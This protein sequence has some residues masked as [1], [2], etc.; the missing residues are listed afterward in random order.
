MKLNGKCQ[1]NPEEFI[2]A[3]AR[4]REGTAN[5]PHADVTGTGRDFV[6]LP[7][8]IA[9]VATM[10]IGSRLFLGNISRSRG[11]MDVLTSFAM[12]LFVIVLIETLAPRIVR[13]I[14][15][16][17]AGT[18]LV[19]FHLLYGAYF[20]FFNYTVPFDIFRQWQD[21][22]VVGKYGG[23]LIS[24]YELVVAVVL[25]LVFLVWIVFRSVKGKLLLFIILLGI[26]AI[27]WTN[28]LTRDI[29]RSAN[30]KAALPD[31]LHKVG[32][33]HFMLKMEKRR[34]LR[35]LNNIET[36]I[37]RHLDGYRR[38]KDG[39]IAVD[40]IEPSPKSECAQYNI[41]LIL[42][43]SV[44]AYECGFLGAKPSFTPRLDELTRQ[45]KVYTD[46]YSNGTRTV[47]AE[48]SLLCS[49]YPNPVGSLTY[50]INPRINITSLPQ[51]LSEF[52]YDTLWFSGYTA[53]FHNKRAFLSHHGIQ[54]IFDRD[55]LPKPTQ[56]T[57]G[58]GMA[59]GEMFEHVWSILKDSNQPF[60]A[61]ITTLSNHCGERL[62]Y[63]TEVDTPPVEGPVPFRKYMQGTYYTDHTVSD[64]I[65]KVR[66]STLADNT[67]III[68]GDHGLWLFPHGLKDP[69]QRLETFFRM[70]LCVWGPRELIGPG[71]DDTLGSHID[72]AP[73]VMDMLNIRRTNTFLGQSLLNTDISSNDRYV[74]AFFG[75]SSYFRTGDVL[76]LPKV[77]M[78]TEE[79]QTGAYVR[80]EEGRLCGRS[81]ISLFAL[82]GDLLRDP[83]AGTSFVD[84]L[85][86]KAISKRIDDITLLT[87][88]GTYF[89]AFQG[90]R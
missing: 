68:T 46:Y 55:V 4:Q 53:D 64:F 20:R 35:I 79:M 13:G 29:K 88:Y 12:V 51:I 37:P 45:A 38:V 58:W 50:L 87:A 82:R 40:P 77:T 23:N 39:G 48:L 81:Q 8:R 67:I 59:D 14:L 15:L 57:I 28:R 80:G 54:K 10:L 44:R 17:L 9:F 61:Q 36:A 56:P 5:A 25:P 66:S 11:R 31:I 7:V 85:R 3:A 70:P 19:F 34:F 84:E 63:P 24:I 26:M 47:S 22:F 18:A 32:R 21:L 75:N 65:E 42:M 43:E 62:D 2:G 6:S 1:K 76:A 78:Q 30:T 90:I 69:L 16:F 71:R 60:F 49:V 86:A 27:G 33:Y 41:I 52:G 89:G 74:T 83:H 72:V 73:T